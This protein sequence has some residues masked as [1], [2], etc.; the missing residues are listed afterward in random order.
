KFAPVRWNPVG[1]DYFH[2]LGTDLVLGRDFTEADS[3][4]APKVMVVNET[5]VKRYLRDVNPLGHHVGL[6]RGENDFG[7]P[8]TIVGVA[9]DSKFTQVRETARPMAFVPYTQVPGV[10]T[11]QIELRTRGNPLTLL[12]DVRRVAQDFGPDLPLLQP[13]TQQEQFESSYSD[14]KIVSRLSMFFGLLAALLVATGL[15]GNL[16]FR[17]SRRTA[18]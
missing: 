14:Q 1:P 3:A 11:M 16:A 4:T 18:E 10:S 8:Y 6:Q 2:V 7:I 9:R 12:P 13:T 15:Y 17:V 5:F